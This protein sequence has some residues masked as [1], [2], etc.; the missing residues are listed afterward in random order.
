MPRLQTAAFALFATIL[1]GCAQPGP[2]PA[3]TPPGST[4]TAEPAAFAVGRQATPA[5]IEEARRRAGASRTRVLRP[6]QVVTMEFDGSRLNLQVDAA[7]RV[8]TVRCG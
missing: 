5:L 6:G 7:D 1:A 3:P 8:L 2:A 4:C